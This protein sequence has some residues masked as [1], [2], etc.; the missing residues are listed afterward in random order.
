MEHVDYMILSTL[1]KLQCTFCEDETPQNLESLVRE[2]VVEG[3]VKL[4]WAI[5][6]NFK[7]KI[8]GYKLPVHAAQKFQVATLIAN[9]VATLIANTVNSF[10]LKDP[11]GYHTLLYANVFEIRRIFLTLI[12]KL[13]IEKIWVEKNLSNF[14]RLIENVGEKVKNDQE[15]NWVPEFCRYFKYKYNGRFWQQPETPE[16][17]NFRSTHYQK[18]EKLEARHSLCQSLNGSNNFDY[19]FSAIEFPNVPLKRPALPPKPKIAPKPAPKPRALPRTI[20]PTE[21]TNHIDKENEREIIASEI[22]LIKAEIDSQ[23]HE[24]VELRYAENRLEDEIAWYKEVETQ[25]DEKLIE[26]LK[27]PENSII[28]LQTELSQIHENDL[29]AQDTFLK[30]KEE[31]QQQ[32]SV[33]REAKGIKSNRE[34]MKLYA[35]ELQKLINEKKISLTENLRQISKLKKKV[36]NDISDNERIEYQSR[37]IEIMLNVEVQLKERQRIF[38]AIKQLDKEIILL[39][40][41]LGRTY[42]VV[43]NWM[44]NVA[45]RDGQLQKAYNNMVTMHEK[46]LAIRKIIEECGS[47]S[48]EIDDLTDE[49]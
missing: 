15:A 16:F 33:L 2:D 19:P 25:K 30:T 8:T 49:N 46:C 5:D 48:R 9:T 7:D 32:L 22:A 42:S 18:D 28:L 13:P 14:E 11:I 6:P 3:I 27:D 12:E 38:E 43:D 24:I 36:V 45:G 20:I 23:K 37:I 39:D 29:R 40:G 26:L 41:S 10:G 44:L 34:Q 47:I 35:L 17:I 31:L 4:L 1:S 21:E